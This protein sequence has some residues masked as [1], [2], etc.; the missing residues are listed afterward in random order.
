[1][2]EE[3]SGWVDPVCGSVRDCGRDA[4]DVEH[5]AGSVNGATCVTA[6]KVGVSWV[7]RRWDLRRKFQKAIVYNP[8]VVKYLNSSRAVSEPYEG[9]MSTYRKG[10]SKCEAG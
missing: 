6:G 4:I 10:C 3:S 5:T 7:V 9:E 8:R 2:V 1:M